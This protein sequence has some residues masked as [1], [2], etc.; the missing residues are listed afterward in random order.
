MSRRKV[1][2]KAED[3]DDMNGQKLADDYDEMHGKKYSRRL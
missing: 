3:Y 1:R 2:K